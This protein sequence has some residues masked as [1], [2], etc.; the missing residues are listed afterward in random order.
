MDEMYEMLKKKLDDM[1][2]IGNPVVDFSF[3][4]VSRLYQQICMMKQVREI[5]KWCDNGYS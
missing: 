5:V 3:E 4:E 1:R 2:E